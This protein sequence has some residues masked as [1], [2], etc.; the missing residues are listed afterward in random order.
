MLEILGD[1]KIALCRELT[2]LHE[3][4]IRGNISE[5]LD[6]VDELK[7]EMVV[8]VEGCKNPETEEVV[9]EQS[10]YSQIET[11][12]ASGMSSKDAIKQVAKERNLKKN[13]VYQTYLNEKG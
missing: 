9:Y 4:I 7:G 1:R 8:V 12:I 2:K 3:E 6:I 10:V 13:E 11:Y 5:V